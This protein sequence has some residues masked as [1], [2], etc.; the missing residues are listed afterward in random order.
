MNRQEEARQEDEWLRVEHQ[1]CSH[2]LEAS[3]NRCWLAATLFLGAAITTLALVLTRP[4]APGSVTIVAVGVVILLP[5]P[6]I[7]SCFKLLHWVRTGN[8]A[9]LW[10]DSHKGEI[11]SR[12]PFGWDF[13]HFAAW[14]IIVVWIVVIILA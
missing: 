12:V 14:L 3:A 5:N 2:K 10:L 9:E 13:L 7:G 1:V 11:E 6:L 4:I 8:G